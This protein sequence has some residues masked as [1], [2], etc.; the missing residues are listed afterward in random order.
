MA[1]KR[2]SPALAIIL[3]LAGAAQAR[4]Q[5]PPQP[6]TEI[7]P[8]APMAAPPA[9]AAPSSVTPPA[10]AIRAGEAVIDRSGAEVGRIQTLIESPA[11][12]M[13][14]VQID[15]KM[16]SLPQRTLRLQGETV[17]SSQSKAEM[18]AAAGA[19]R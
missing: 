4:C 5:A 11:G 13:V 9:G 7:P 12:P 1:S 16:V 10:P 14:V 8:V 19:P 17:V 6:A 15:G 2:I 3:A 18:L